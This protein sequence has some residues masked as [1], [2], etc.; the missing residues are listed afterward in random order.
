MVWDVRQTA[1]EC[2]RQGQLTACLHTVVLLV[3]RV[4]WSYFHWGQGLGGRP[5][6]LRQVGSVRPTVCISQ[7]WSSPP[8]SQYHA[9]STEVQ[10]ALAGCCLCR[11][12]SSALGTWRWGLEREKAV[13]A[14][15]EIIPGLW[16][17]VWSGKKRVPGP[18]FQDKSSS[19]KYSIWERVADTQKDVCASS[20]TWHIPWRRAQWAPVAAGTPSPQWPGDWVQWQLWVSK[21][22][23]C[24]EGPRFFLSGFKQ[25]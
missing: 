14:V 21:G 12:L 19:F 5:A 20:S 1:G 3:L 11:A 4:D 7:A 6:S 13:D 9:C 16:S 8:S 18:T 22:G 23:G 25:R 2:G 10:H 15:L 24:F 17:G